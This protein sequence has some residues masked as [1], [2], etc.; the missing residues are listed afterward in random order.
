MKSRTKGPSGPEGEEETPIE[1]QEDRITSVESRL[2]AMQNQIDTNF[3]KLM[4][5]IV[6]LTPQR[7]DSSAKSGQGAPVSL[8][9]HNLNVVQPLEPQSLAICPTPEGSVLRQYDMGDAE[10]ELTKSFQKAP[11]GG[12]PWELAHASGLIDKGALGYQRYV[13]DKGPLHLLVPWWLAHPTVTMD[14]RSSQHLLPILVKEL[15]DA[16]AMAKSPRAP[17][18]WCLT[19]ENF[20]KVLMETLALVGPGARGTLSA[21]VE[22]TA[23]WHTESTIVGV[24]IEGLGFHPLLQRVLQQGSRPSTL[25]DLFK[26]AGQLLRTD[27]ESVIIEASRAL[28]RLQLKRG[29]KEDL[30][31]MRGQFAEIAATLQ[32]HVSNQELRRS[33]L[34]VCLR[35]PRTP[36]GFYRFFHSPEAAKTPT[37]EGLWTLLLERVLDAR[38]ARELDSGTGPRVSLNNIVPEAHTDIHGE[39]SDEADADSLTLMLCHMTPTELG[40]ELREICFECAGKGH[41]AK[42]C[43]HKESPTVTMDKSMAKTLIHLSRARLR[44]GARRRAAGGGYRPPR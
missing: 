44:D 9:L 11:P 42:D 4:Q 32:G 28:A 25:K 30:Y 36:E 41:L 34:D 7:N 6:G 19:L 40:T 14:R 31:E 2:Q 18:A 23:F 17:G 13:P 39:E 38:D 1:S 35:S 24:A 16:S 22:Q 3:E 26:L 12:F 37:W 10:E 33:F 29:N 5:A 21:G 8:P 27:E 43:P 15:P 20:A